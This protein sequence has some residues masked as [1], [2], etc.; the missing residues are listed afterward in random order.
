M[1]SAVL[2]PKRTISQY[3]FFNGKIS[4]GFGVH[5]VRFVPMTYQYVT[6][7]GGFFL[8]WFRPSDRFN[9]ILLICIEKNCDMRP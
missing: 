3:N 4:G 1:Q 7:L 8:L 5:F 2:R 6:S 9:G